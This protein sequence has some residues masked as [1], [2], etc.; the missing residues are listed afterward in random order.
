MRMRTL[1]G[2]AVI[3][4]V[5]AGCSNG[6]T[7]SSG[8]SP[9]SGASSASAPTSGGASGSSGGRYSYGSGGY[10]SG[11]STGPNGTSAAQPSVT[12]TQAN[13]S[14]S[15]STVTVKSGATIEVDNSTPSTPHTFTITGKGIDVTV[16]PG[17]SQ[18]VKIT[19][20][21]GTYPFECRFH[22]SLGMTGTLIVK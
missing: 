14:F 4:L 7:A 6:S 17:S 19:L 5:A 13:Y 16:G 11:S 20:P 21:P 12:V 1:A 18:D 9:T 22:A 15:P 2:I 3:A 10:G 8:G